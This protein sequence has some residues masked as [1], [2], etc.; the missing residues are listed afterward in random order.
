MSNAHLTRPFTLL[1]AISVQSLTCL[2]T[3]VIKFEKK[4]KNKTCQFKT[5]IGYPNFSDLFKRIVN[6]FKRAGYTCT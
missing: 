1:F 4:K 5:I 2:E 6:L 3:N